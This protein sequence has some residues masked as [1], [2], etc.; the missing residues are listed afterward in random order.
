LGSRFNLELQRAIESIAQGFDGSPDLTIERRA[1]EPEFR[2]VFL[3]R[4]PHA[5][6]FYCEDGRA[7]VVAVA[8]LR[9]MPGYWRDRAG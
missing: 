7:I 6:I 8:H 9:R 2:R 5:V 3:G 4:F 1:E